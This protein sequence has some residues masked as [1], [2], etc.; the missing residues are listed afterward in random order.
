MNKCTMNIIWH[1]SL[2]HVV[3][4]APDEDDRS[5]LTVKRKFEVQFLFEETKKMQIEGLK[6]H[7]FT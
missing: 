1:E 3:E 7:I 5:I 6:V 2:F 4:N